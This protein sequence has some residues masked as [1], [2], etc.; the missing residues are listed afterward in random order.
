M[1][2]ERKVAAIIRLLSLAGM[3]FCSAALAE[4]PVEFMLFFAGFGCS[5]LSALATMIL[6]RDA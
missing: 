6:E 2:T 1:I 3:L 5:V 4:N